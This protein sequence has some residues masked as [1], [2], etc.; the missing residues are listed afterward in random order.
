MTFRSLDKEA[1]AIVVLWSEVDEAESLSMAGLF[2]GGSLLW[3]GSSM[4][5]LR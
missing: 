1:Q 5:G 3:W 4:V 2:Y